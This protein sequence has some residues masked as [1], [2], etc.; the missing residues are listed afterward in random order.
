M[1][2]IDTRCTVCEAITEDVVR[3]AAMWP[4]TPPCQCGGQTEQIHL[5]P[6]TRW[7]PDPVVVYQN[8]ADGSFRFPPDTTSKSTAMY[9]KLG[10]TRVE[11]RGSQDVRRFEKHMNAHERRQME[12][13]NER[14]QE[15]RE[16]GEKERRGELHQRMQSMSRFGRDL[17]RAAM[18]Q[19]DNRP[20]KYA[21]DAGFRVSVYSD[22]RSTVGRDPRGRN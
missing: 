6:R 14:E 15:Q 22:D 9:D 11:L 19:T 7:T 20:R 10:Y 12:R 2:L 8:P 16:R 13:R 21:G 1:A 17:A 4:A 3:P 18:A 5:P